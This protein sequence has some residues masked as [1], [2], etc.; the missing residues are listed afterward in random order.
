MDPAGGFYT[1][2]DTGSLTSLP[3]GKAVDEWLSYWNTPGAYVCLVFDEDERYD[4][5]STADFIQW[6]ETRY[7]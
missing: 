6:L 7:G 5:D 3:V 4:F 1:H 2:D